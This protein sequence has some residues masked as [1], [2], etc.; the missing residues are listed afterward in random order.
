MTTMIILNLMLATVIFATIVGLLS[1]AIIT[2]SRDDGRQASPRRA[3]TERG[4]PALRPLAVHTE[5]R[6]SQRRSLSA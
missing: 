4:A 6:H 5:R 1:W 3:R 2:Q